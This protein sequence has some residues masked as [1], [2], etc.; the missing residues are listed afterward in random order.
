MPTT[1]ATD[2]DDALREVLDR[3]VDSLQTAT[4]DAKTDLHAAIGAAFGDK[5]TVE[6]AAE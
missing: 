3:I 4:E 6:D 2:R 5:P 1:K